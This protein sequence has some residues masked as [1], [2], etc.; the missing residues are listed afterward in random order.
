MID[1]K[2]KEKLAI[3]SGQKEIGDSNVNS[4]IHPLEIT[5]KYQAPIKF[6]CIYPGFSSPG[7]FKCA[8]GISRRGGKRQARVP[9]LMMKHITANN[10][11]TI[12]RIT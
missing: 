1:Y 9:V 4:N 11:I 10:N 7:D 12:R 2:S 8:P 5:T 6:N 3:L